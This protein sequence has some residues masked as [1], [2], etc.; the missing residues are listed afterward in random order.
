MNFRLLLVAALSTSAFAADVQVV[1]Q[2]VARVNGD[3]VAQDDIERTSVQLRQELKQH[4]VPA[5]ELDEEFAKDNK[6]IL[7]HK[8]DDLLLVQKGKELNINVDSE[9]TKYMTNIQRQA[10]IAD[11]EKFHSYI[12]EQAGMSYEEFLAEAKN[13]ALKRE[14]I[15]QEVGR[16]IVISDKEVSDYYNAHK[17]DFNREEKVFLSEILV[18]T[19][20]KDAAGQ[21][22][23]EKKAKQLAEQAARGE[24]F[25]DLARDNSDAATAKAGGT[26]GGYKKG[27]LAPIFEKAV[28]DLPKGG[29]TKPIKIPTGWEILKVDD[30][31][32]AGLESLEEAKPEI[33]NIL[34]GPK[35]EPQVRE[36]LTN[37]RKAAFL[38]IKPGYVDTHAAPGQNTTWQEVAELKPET[39]TKAQVEDE[40]RK[41]RFLG[42]PIPGTSTTVSGKSS[43]R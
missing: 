2:I 1:D 36:Y 37:L 12:R 43:S 26:L 24:R 18:S 30:H 34:F 6:D 11:P 13:E 40:K 31:S 5:A 28:W 38:Q 21:A 16:K 7:S 22:A 3:I 33:E 19:E 8:I 9:V 35:M 42:I 10:G 17:N 39:V 27:E 32:H 23:A 14:V 25:A 4:G 41:K 29:V 20:N 15:Q